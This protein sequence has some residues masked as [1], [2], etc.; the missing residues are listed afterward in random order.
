VTLE[1]VVKAELASIAPAYPTI[2]PSGAAD[3]CIVYQ[4]ISAP[5][6]EVAEYVRPRV[7]LAC[8]AKGYG[9]AVA[10]GNQARALF[11]NRHVT[12]SGVHY[13]AWVEN[14]YDGPPENDAGRY[15][16]IVDVRF[17]Y[18]NPTA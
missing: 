17:D 12:T 1:E 11:H 3:T 16:R 5:E 7:Q 8:Y 4:L 9:A 14:A 2:M 13:R 18:R 10:L 15:V 6:L